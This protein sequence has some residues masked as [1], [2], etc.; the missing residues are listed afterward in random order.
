[1]LVQD[2]FRKNELSLIPGGS[3]IT[4]VHSKGNRVT[5][6]KIKNIDAYCKYLKKD[7]NVTEIWIGGSLIWKRN[8]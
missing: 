8:Q 5:Y 3:V 7:P 6:D 4:V 1:M 2:K